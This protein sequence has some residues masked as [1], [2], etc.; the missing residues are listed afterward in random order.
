MF[1]NVPKLAR[2]NSAY[3]SHQN[4][5]RITQR[6]PSKHS[7]VKLLKIRQQKNLRIVRLKILLTREHKSNNNFSS[8]AR[9][10]WHKKELAQE[11]QLLKE[12]N[13]QS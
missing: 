12:N 6:I 2:L 3:S 11:F 9:W 10:N 8:E 1:E 4:T 5:Q 13:W 7:R